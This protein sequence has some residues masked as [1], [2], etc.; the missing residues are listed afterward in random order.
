[1]KE[2]GLRLHIDTIKLKKSVMDHVVTNMVWLIILESATIRMNLVCEVDG[3]ERE[4]KAYFGSTVGCL[5]LI[6]QHWAHSASLL[7]SPLHP[8]E[9]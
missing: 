2:L 8:E 6:W 9:L 1:M 5:C 4:N 7:H 3:D